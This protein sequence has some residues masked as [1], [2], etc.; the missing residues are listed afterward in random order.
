VETYRNRQSGASAAWAADSGGFCGRIA[1][2][3]D[4][5]DNA[6]GLRPEPEWKA[7]G[8]K[9]PYVIYVVLMLGLFGFL[10]LMAYLAWTNG[11]IPKR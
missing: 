7:P 1:C 3:S 10:V 6:S 8:W 2:M 5:K 11:W 9:H 4:R